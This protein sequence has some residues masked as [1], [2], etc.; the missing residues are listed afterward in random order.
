V[1]HL[2]VLNDV[3]P[4]RVPGEVVL[5]PPLHCSVHTAVMPATQKR[6]AT[7]TCSDKADLQS[8]RKEQGMALKLHHDYACTTWLNMLG[9]V[10]HDERRSMMNGFDFSQQTVMLGIAATLERLLDR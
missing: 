6:L 10:G 3:R 9:A 5:H 7:G 4:G 2:D 8:N 1:L